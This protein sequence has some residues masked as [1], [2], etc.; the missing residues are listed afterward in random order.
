WQL[1]AS[2][3]LRSSE[4]PLRAL[5]NG[6]Y[7]NHAAIQAR[8]QQSDHR[9]WNLSVGAMHFSDG[10]N[11]WTAV[12]GGRERLYSAP[13]LQADLL[14]GIAASHNA[15]EDAAYFNPKS[16]LEV[17]PSLKLTHTLYRRYDTALEHSLLLG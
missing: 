16:D 10:N 1:G 7:A 6:I 4:T 12:L 14:V 17:L 3:A 11:R 15:H 5:R 9:E 8:W 13:G 2:M